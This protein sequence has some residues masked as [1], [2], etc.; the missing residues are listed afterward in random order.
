MFALIFQAVTAVFVVVGC[1][2]VGKWLG[3]KVFKTKKEVSG[4][5]RAAQQASVAMREAGYK[6]FP[7][8]LDNLVVGDVDDFF[9]DIKD[10]STMLKSGNE[11][12]AKELD[13]VFDRSLTARLRTPEGRA[14]VKVRLEMA[15]TVATEVAKA[16]APLVVAAALAVL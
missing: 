2:V 13:G 6:L 1:L 14:A 7:N 5:K 12:I 3:K 9:Q 11:V 8:M 16:S 4:V 15:E 10:F